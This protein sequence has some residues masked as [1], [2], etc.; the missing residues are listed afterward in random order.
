MRKELSRIPAFCAATLLA[1]SAIAQ[2]DFSKV[3]IQTDKLAEGVY[4]MTGAGGNLGVSVGEDGV[5]LI[6]DQFAPL[7]PKIEA[8]IAKLNA[9]PVR[10]LLNTHW[11]FDHTGGNQNLGKAGAIIV[12]QENVRKR[13][14]QEGFIAFLG[15]KTKPEPAVAL[16]I[17]TF[18]RDVTF[19]LNGDEI[20]A[21]HAPRAHTDGDTIVH[22]AKSDVIHT[23]DTFFNGLYPFIDTSSGGS[24]AGVLAAADRVLKMA[25]EKTK[26]IPGHGPLAGKAE[27]KKY[28]DMLAAVS[29]RISGQIKQGKT[30]EQVIASRPSAQF[31]AVWGKGFLPPD[32]FV[33]MLYGNLKK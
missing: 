16:P 19:H 17:V 6:D 3:E 28:R 31:D 9:K 27:L 26:I 21:F 24:V 2:D 32:K 20:R 23:G 13:L 1:A 11:H 15:M 25:G 7:T 14:S 12:A 33:E 30:L 5:F 8:A 22:F 10:F 29:G 18:T 4:M